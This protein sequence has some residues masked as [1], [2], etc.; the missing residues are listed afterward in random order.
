M[1]HGAETRL[2]ALLGDPIAH[3]LSPGLQNAAIRAAGLDAVYLALR[4]DA[5][6][7]HGLIRGIAGAGGGGN[8]TIPHKATAAEAVEVQ[9][10][11]VQRTRACNTFWAEGGRLH[12]DNT[13]VAGFD[14]AAR[15]LIGAPA[16]ARALVVGG[17][18]G[19]K[20]AGVAPP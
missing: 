1:S 7:V 19:D 13:D 2:I 5:D 18:G 11:A 9:S 17:G 15:A 20:G 4:C 14:A 16:G 10:L 3:S 12:G 8:V 6:H